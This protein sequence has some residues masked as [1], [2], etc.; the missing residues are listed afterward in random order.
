MYIQLSFQVGHSISIHSIKEILKIKDLFHAEID[1]QEEYQKKII[2][3]GEQQ[4]KEEIIRTSEQK[5]GKER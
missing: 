2:I 5:E 4:Q 1:I 3:I